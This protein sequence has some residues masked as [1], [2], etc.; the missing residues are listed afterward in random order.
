MKKKLKSS[1]SKLQTFSVFIFLF[2]FLG[3]SLAD[4]V[5]LEWTGNTED[6]LAGYNIY[7]KTG[8]CCE[9]YQFLTN[10]PP[11]PTPEKFISGLDD[12][13]PHFF[14]VTAFPDVGDESGYSN[15]V[16]TKAP[17]ITSLPSV[18]YNANEIAIIEWETDMEG[19]S[20]IRW[21]RETNPWYSGS[22]YSLIKDSMVTQH[23]ITL[24]GLAY[25]TRYYFQV[26]TKNELGYGPDS[27]S[28]EYDNNPSSTYSFKTPIEP[29]PDTT[30]PQIVLQPYAS[31]IT[32]SEVLIKWETD[33]PA[34]SIV[35]YGLTA[36]YGLM[37]V[38][39]SYSLNHEVLI[40]YLQ[41]DSTYHFRISSTDYAGMTVT[42]DDFQFRTDIQPDDKPPIFTSPPTVTAITDTSA[43]I[44]W[45]TNEPSNTHAQVGP[46]STWWNNYPQ[47]FVDWNRQTQHSITIT[48][49]SPNTLYYCRVASGDTSFNKL[50]SLEFT[51]ITDSIPDVK[52]PKIISAPTVISMSDSTATIV[53]DTDEPA[54][55]QIQYGKSIDGSKNWGDYEKTK[56]EG[57]Y[58]THHILQ[59]TGLDPST[60]Y[61][62]RVGSA[63]A[64]GNGPMTDL[65]DNN[66]SGQR[67]FTTHAKSDET[68][69]QITSPPTITARTDQSVTIEWST[70]EPSNTMV[71]YAKE[72]REW[73]SY[74][75]TYFDP[76]GL[77]EHRAVITGLKENTKYYFRVGGSDLFNNGP[78]KGE[79]DSNPS[80]EISIKT[81][82]I[83]DSTAP[84]IISPPTVTAKTNHV[85]VVEWTTD[86]LSNSIVQ[87]GDSQGLWGDY[88]YTEN[89]S[90][91]VT[92][93]VVTLTDLSTA[94]T[95]YFRVGSIDSSGNGPEVSNEVIFTTESSADNTSP[96]I[97]L[98]PT[99]TGITDTTA[100][101]EWET[102]EP[103][104][105]EVKY[106]IDVAPD[107]G[108]GPDVNWSDTSLSVLS[109]DSM[110]TMHSITLSNLI[111]GAHYCFRVGS[112]DAAGNGP[113]Q[114]DLSSNNPFPKTMFITKMEKDDSAPKIISVPVV[115]AIDNRSAIIEWETDEP[116]NSMVKYGESES[117]QDQ[118][119]GT[120]WENLPLV[121]S[122]AVLVTKH[123]LTVTGLNPLTTYVFRAGST[124]VMGNGPDLNQDSTN[125]SVIGTFMT[126][127]GPDEISPIITNLD[128]FFVTNL[129][130]LI[131]WNTDEPCNSVIQYG[132]DSSSWG[133]YI[134]EESDAGITKYHSITIT[135][136]Q[137]AT[138]YYFRAGS[139]DARGNGP[140]L[141]SGETE[142]F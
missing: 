83:S 70:D 79:N 52:A 135:G 2:I 126:S 37:E 115:T 64:D 10:A 111:Q 27:Y 94:K 110:V 46:I 132:T 30:A 14:V 16:N 4:E 95:Y 142:S 119:G 67:R 105:S 84:Q 48:G 17:Q 3:I 122:D 47:K 33:E 112:T 133:N 28:E 55:S 62:Y 127:E 78:N 68:A 91:M 39:S 124:D 107:S 60:S 101:I 15:E 108:A 85:A 74:D 104:N 120:T 106:M 125:A 73:D 59:L 40:S 131:T 96:R 58:L 19:N 99:A 75:F 76:I 51:F 130:A 123:H 88:D 80:V 90:N 113:D 50:I 103:S 32:D 54:N 116:S 140:W 41:P 35:E 5:T 71:Q 36:S 72:S 23:S 11:S 93:H 9:P 53:W 42:S 86:E 57:K 138:K 114:D 25:D 77:I 18:V 56:E 139:V 13:K 102:D 89:D 20:E 134:F 118:V 92:R 136:L 21:G 137:P 98:P 38:I 87:Y 34:T 65:I 97:I 128:V 141:N 61:L 43:I 66:P 121:E 7:Y 8:S 31:I 44:E 29:V 45:E 22:T 82:S 129:T 1:Y 24:E 100:I 81:N 117:T 6:N 63:D 49:L 109:T 26:G 12:E 69:P